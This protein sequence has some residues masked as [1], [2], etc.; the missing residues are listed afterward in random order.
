MN[1]SYNTVYLKSLVTKVISVIGGSD[2]VACVIYVR[3]V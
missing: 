1:D 3:L 2:R